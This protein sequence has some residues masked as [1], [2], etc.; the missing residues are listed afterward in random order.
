MGKYLL[1]YRHLMLI[2][3][4]S[5][6]LICNISGIVSGDM[7]P[8]IP[9]GWDYHQAS[10][11]GCAGMT[12]GGQPGVVTIVADRQT[13]GNLIVNAN[14]FT[15]D[16]NGGL[17]FISNSYPLSSSGSSSA[18]NFAYRGLQAALVDNI[19]YC[20]IQNSQTT[21]DLNSFSVTGSASRGTVNWGPAKAVQ[22]SSAGTAMSMFKA[23]SS[24]DGIYFISQQQ[25]AGVPVLD[26]SHLS[27]E[28]LEASSGIITPTQLCQ[29]GSSSGFLPPDSMIYSAMITTYPGTNNTIIVGTSDSGGQVYSWYINPY[30]PGQRGQTLL[31]STSDLKTYFDSKLSSLTLVQGSFDG[32]V[33]GI[34]NL[35]V[36]AFEQQVDF[37]TQTRGSTFNADLTKIG[38]PGYTWSNANINYN[39]EEAKYFVDP[40]I[41]TMYCTLQIP[42]SGGKL[43]TNLVVYD[44]LQTTNILGNQVSIQVIGTILSNILVP[45]SGPAGTCDTLSSFDTYGNLALPV[46]FIDGVPPIALNGHDLDPA[47]VDSKTILVQ[48]DTKETDSSGSTESSVSAG[49]KGEFDDGMIGVGDSY[50]QTIKQ[51]TTASTDFSTTM[52]DTFGLDA[53]GGNDYAYMVYLAP[54][55]KTQRFWVYDFNGNAPTTGDP[56]TI[57][58]TYPDPVTPYK[59][60]FQGYNITNPPRSGWM[61]GALQSPWYNNFDDWNWATMSGGWHNRDWSQSPQA[62]KNFTIYTFE[63]DIE[64]NN[65][66]SQTT[67]YDMTDSLSHTYEVDDA[68]KADAS[69]LGFGISNDVTYSQESGITNSIQEGLEFYWS[70]AM[71]DNGGCGYQE[72]VIEPQIV[73]PIVGAESLPWA[74]GAYASYEPWFVTYNLVEADMT[75]NCAASVRDQ[76]VATAVEPRL[77]GNITMN[78]IV[79]TKGEVVELKADPAPGYVFSHWKVWGV[80]LHDLSSP[81]VQGLVKSDLSTVRAY[82]E[83]SGSDEIQVADFVI[84]A[85]PARGNV[86]IM[87]KIPDGLTWPVAMDLNNPLMITTGRENFLFGPMMG[88]REVLSSQEILYSTPNNTTGSATLNLNF[89]T[90]TW[91]F[92]GPLVENLGR[93]VLG[94]HTVRLGISGK[95]F[96]DV[97]DL[98]L[99]GN[100]MISWK[101]G[102]ESVTNDLFS[103]DVN[104]KIQGNISFPVMNPDLN[105][106]QIQNAKLMNTTIDPSVPVTL[107]VNHVKITFDN[108]TEVDNQRYSY[109]AS[110]ND[111]SVRMVFDTSSKTWQVDMRGKR[112]S[113]T[114]WPEQFSIGLQ[115]G[116]KGA[117]TSINP[118]IEANLYFPKRESLHAD[119][120][121]SPDS[122]T[123]RL[124]VKFSDLSTG[125]PT[126]WNWTFGDGSTSHE[127]NPE[128]V[129]SGVGRYTV[130][131]QVSN[132]QGHDTIRN[133]VQIT[134]NSGRVTGPNGFIWVTSSPSGARVSVD[135]VYIGDTPLTSSGV[136]AGACLVKVSKDGFYDWVGRIQV[137]KETFTYIPKVIL[138]KR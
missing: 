59:Y 132:T 90:K 5:G 110:E 54:Q 84:P 71:P 4:M 67:S 113:H 33:T 89:N 12:V 81:V 135:G 25:N 125:Q 106:F 97:Q 93:S 69:I 94:T 61:S 98:P 8:P 46:G 27:K 55:F 47:N 51:T 42:N 18:F 11:W 53:Q 30:N 82:F 35:V 134:V 114:V 131:L 43:R 99:A 36:V 22:F 15:P 2:V 16:S 103:F 137:S 85:E 138:R 75:P 65:G 77:S 126:M 56:K 68:H 73:T 48:T 116:S 83:K 63:Q 39:E 49:F 58:I 128:H 91:E 115:I 34:N 1:V 72:V 70:M 38:T 105:T 111:L 129:Y 108:A 9:V 112:L 40:A 109:T 66:G 14:S 104:T 122:G 127:Q 101:G 130:T 6:L 117:R 133:P 121:V 79:P 23:I 31:F 100:E 95:N 136:S 88:E 50:K 52:V 41:S 24:S 57:Y 64:F 78:P 21:L 102:A 19:I 13:S 123:P 37:N 60:F 44:V 87:G 20:F 107:T 96:T 29:I 3:M 124:S 74:P 119:F 17:N 7:V 120:A 92:S 62:G 80:D 32:D 28:Q 10:A 118:G 86:R 45:D 26:I 76:R